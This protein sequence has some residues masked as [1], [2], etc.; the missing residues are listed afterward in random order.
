MQNMNKK[1]IIYNWLTDKSSCAIIF[2]NNLEMAELKTCAKKLGF[3]FIELLAKWQDNDQNFNV[4]F[5]LIKNISKF[6]TKKLIS[7]LQISTC[8]YKDQ[9]GLK[10]INLNNEENLVILNKNIDKNF[11]KE[12]ISAISKAKINDKTFELYKVEPPRPSYFN[13]NERYLKIF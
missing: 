6:Q 5:L 10:E 3:G 8:V 7:E 13:D 12:L 1:N 2:P 4:K 9:V 11:L